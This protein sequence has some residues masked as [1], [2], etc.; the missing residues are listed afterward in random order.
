[1]ARAPWENGKVL[2]AKRMMALMALL[3]VACGSAAQQTAQ[4]PAAGTLD[5]MLAPIAL[6]PDPLLAQMLMSAVDPAKVSQLDQW[7]RSSPNL[8]GTEL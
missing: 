2:M 5:Q 4:Q 3:F 6:Y 8:K 7:L 1:M